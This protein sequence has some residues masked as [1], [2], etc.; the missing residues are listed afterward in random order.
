MRSWDD[1][2]VIYHPAAGNTHLLGDAAAQV[3]AL[4]QAQKLAGAASSHG[5]VR[6]VDLANALAGYC[7]PDEQ[8]H[9]DEL[10]MTI[11]SDLESLGLIERTRL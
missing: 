3:L 9:A 2:H 10:S 8:P 6:T 5:A 7:S 11:L 1:E 4:L